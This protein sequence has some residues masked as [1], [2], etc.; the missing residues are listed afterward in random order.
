MNIDLTN[1]NSDLPIEIEYK[2]LSRS[3]LALDIQFTLE[4]NML[5]I[6][7]NGFISA[8]IPSGYELYVI[9]KQNEDIIYDERHL[10]D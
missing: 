5:S 9:V 1:Y 2:S 3:E 8:G 7:D 10:I 6:D 4:G